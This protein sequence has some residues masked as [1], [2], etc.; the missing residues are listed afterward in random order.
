MSP[1]VGGP[2]TFQYEWVRPLIWIIQLIRCVFGTSWNWVPCD[3]QLITVKT[4]TVHHPNGHFHLFKIYKYIAN[5]V[6]KTMVTF[7]YILE[8]WSVFA[9]DCTCMGYMTCLYTLAVIRMLL[10]SFQCYIFPLSPPRDFCLLWQMSIVPLT[11]C[12]QTNSDFWTYLDN[13]K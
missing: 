11:S 10:L 3:Y 4:T 1:P 13:D 6:C 2:H 8:T 12:N 7:L 5:K 9:C